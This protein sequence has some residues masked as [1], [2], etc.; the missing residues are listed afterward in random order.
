MTE[1]KYDFLILCG[2]RMSILVFLKSATI[3][4]NTLQNCNTKIFLTFNY[5]CSV[6]ELYIRRLIVVHIVSTVL[7]RIWCA[8]E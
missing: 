7:I 1:V 2:P 5:H 6:S 8:Y 3:G 4:V